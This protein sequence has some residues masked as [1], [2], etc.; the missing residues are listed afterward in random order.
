[1]VATV[2][3]G[4]AT[5]SHLCALPDPTTPGH[6]RHDATWA[7]Y[8]DNSAD[9]G[10][11]APLKSAL[12]LLSATPSD[13]MA[14]DLGCGS[15]RDTAALLRFGFHVMAVDGRREALLRV[16]RRADVDP[17]RLTCQLASFPDVDLPE[18]VRLINASHS[19]HFC[20]PA[21][22][23]RFW[24]YLWDR[25]APGGRICGHLFG[26]HDHF[27]KNES[28]STFDAD[29]VRALLAPFDVEMYTE[30]RGRVPGKHVFRFVARKPRRAC[31]TI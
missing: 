11:C 22:F 31:A 13:A 19:L 1:M 4:A 3:N 8:D 7:R 25:L 20:P 18:D 27:G 30:S 14:V 6:W 23:M 16:L 29:Q 2:L 10:P 24:A 5:V 21:S 12:Q 28:L 15:G 9:K 26:V 17:A